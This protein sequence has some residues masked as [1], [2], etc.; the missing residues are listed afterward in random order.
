M[1]LSLQATGRSR[2]EDEELQRSTKKVKEYYHAISNAASSSQNSEGKRSSYKERLTGEILGAYEEAFSFENNIETEVDSDDECSDL[3]TGIVAVNLSGSN[4]RAH[5][6]NAL[7]IKVVGKT[8][9]YHFLSSRVMSLWKPSGR[10]DCVDMEKGFFLIRFSLKEDYERVLNDGPLFV[11][12]HYLSIRNWEP[13]FKPSTTSVTF[14]AVWIHLPEL[15]IEYYERS[16]QTEESNSSLIGSDSNHWLIDPMAFSADSTMK[17]EPEHLPDVG[18]SSL[19][20]MGQGESTNGVGNEKMK[21]SSVKA[22]LRDISNQPPTPN[23]D[24][25]DLVAT[26]ALNVLAVELKHIDPKLRPPKKGSE[27][28]PSSCLVQE[29]DSMVRDESPK[30]LA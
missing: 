1:S 27:V 22:P 19:G 18:I 28:K 14:V 26:A 2:E 15:P 30:A 21:V 16:K 13:N 8:V 4:M 9:G 5:W 6:V 7:I 10:M 11:G 3:A 24:M 20:D 12:G 17:A 23:R 25:F 29:E